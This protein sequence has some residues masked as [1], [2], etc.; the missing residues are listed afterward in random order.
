M[1]K[2]P[3]V[4]FILADDERFDTIHAFGNDEIKTPNLDRLVAEGTAF[5]RAHIPGGTSGA[6]CMPSRAMLNSGKT[7]FHLYGAGEQIPQSHTTM[8]QCFRENGYRAIGIGKWHN[9]TESYARSFSDGDEIFFGGMWDHWNVPVNSFHSDG[10]YKN[11]VRSTP[12]FSHANHP[13]D[14]IAERITAGKH[15]TELFTD[16][17]I[18]FI[19]QPHDEPFFLYTALLAPHDPRT[20][21]DRFKNMYDPS[22]ISLPNN[23]A[24]EHPFYFGIDP[25]IGED[26]DESLAAHPRT[27]SEIRRHIAD[28]YAM[29]SHIDENVGRILDALERTKQLDNTIIVYT[30]DNGL[31]VGRHGLMG[32]QNLY[33]HSIRVPL[34][35]RGPGIPKGERRDA[36]VYLMDI[37]PTLCELCGISI[38][39]SV[40][41]KSFKEVIFGGKA[42]RTTMYFAYTHLI[43]AVKDERFKLIRYKLEPDQTQLFDLDEDPDEM[44]NL[45]HD[46]RYRAV[47]DQLE[48]LLLQERDQWEDDAENCFTRMFWEE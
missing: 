36:Y 19:E 43:R 1:E 4:L 20:M 2:K 3:N 47:R 11:L 7:L 13:M 21:P 42:T 26:R 48:K 34:I 9:G 23:F 5:T 41:G 33:D 32:K 44:V 22:K 39:S 30:G 16:A 38:P 29:I 31:A 37:Y 46:P 17:A 45:Y 12:N 24:A 40:E 8:G 14:M 10:K 25:K 18:R 6:V 35:L 15:S 28:Y 27:E